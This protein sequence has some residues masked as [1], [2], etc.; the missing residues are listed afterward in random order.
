LEGKNEQGRM[1]NEIRVTKS[2]PTKD[3]GPWFA[4][5]LF[6]FFTPVKKKPVMPVQHGCL[7]STLA[8]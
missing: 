3:G 8:S 5:L 1:M 4:I 6:F 2:H 7:L